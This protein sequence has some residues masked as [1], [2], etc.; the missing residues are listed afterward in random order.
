VVDDVVT[1][2]GSVIR[3][4]Q[5]CR[6]EGLQIVHVAVLV[7]REEGGLQNIE[8]EV[9]GVPVTAIF[10]KSDLEAILAQEQG[11]V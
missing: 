9:P 7:D 4:V 11:A 8:H 6:E 1:S 3:A 10:K 5:R 2:G